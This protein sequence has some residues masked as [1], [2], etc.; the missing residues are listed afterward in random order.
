[1]YLNNIC[2]P[3]SSLVN[4]QMVHISLSVFK[5]FFVNLIEKIQ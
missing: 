2:L 3:K 1:M 4:E 5:M